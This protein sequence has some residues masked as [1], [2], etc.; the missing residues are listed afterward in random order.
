MVR[1]LARLTPRQ[2]AALVLTD[3]LDLPSEE[4]GQAMGISASTVRT[5]ATQGRA[6]LRERLE[7]DH[8]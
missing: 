1:A 2:R 3:L 6:A 5:L 4:A 7:R 8:E